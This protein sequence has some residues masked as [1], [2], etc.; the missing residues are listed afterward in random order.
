MRTHQSLLGHLASIIDLYAMQR[1]REVHRDIT[2][3][4]SFIEHSEA[5]A[6]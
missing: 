2:L 1:M 4:K 6:A 5:R 3:A